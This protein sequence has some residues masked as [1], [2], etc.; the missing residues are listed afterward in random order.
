MTWC[1]RSRRPYQGT[2]T[3]YGPSCA[4]AMLLFVFVATA[5]A[6]LVKLNNGGELRGKIVQ[7]GNSKQALRLETLTGA[8][9]VVDVDQTQFVTIR[10]AAVEEYETRARR[11]GVDNDSWEAHWE[12]SEWCRQRGL[13]AQRQIHLR[14]VTELSPDFE[15]AQTG[16]GRVW[17]DGSW[18]DR[19]EL[20][21]SKGYVKYKNK[22]ITPQE[23][24]IIEKTSDELQRDKTWI[25]R[26]RVWRAW[27]DGP[28]EDKARQAVAELKAVGDPHAAPAVIK[29][30]A[31]DSRVNVRELAISVL[32]KIGGPKAAIGLVNLALFDESIDIRAAALDGIG[33][34]Q[35]VAAQNAFIQALRNE[36]N[37]VVCRAG[38]AL[39]KIGDKKAVG[40]LIDALVTAHN[41][42]VTSDIPSSPVYSFSADGNFAQNTPSLPPHIEA[43]VRTGQ[44]LPPV[45][46]QSENQVPRKVVSVRVEHRN[47]EVLA[48]LESLTDKDFG[49][50]KRT[51]SLWWAA[52][53]NQGK[54][55]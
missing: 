3:F 7:N 50:D 45:Y 24:E 33:R 26:V 37:F 35:Y 27:L 43:A 25:Q 1:H 52:E 28:S 38:Y 49:Y 39:G 55:K 32:V 29:F 6:D 51:W 41:Y 4:S 12:L 23:L 47:A 54:S 19:D 21:I 8:V 17:H 44:L 5:D 14:R 10:S 11:L 9:V 31:T 36:S 30:L 40:P 16:L 34:E 15:K 18:V 13:S 46:V 22:Y 2:R 20:M 42:Q 48:A 53:K